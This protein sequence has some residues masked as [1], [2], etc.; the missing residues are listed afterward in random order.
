MPSRTNCCVVGCTNTYGSA[1]RNTR[2]Y[3]FPSKPHEIARRKKRV[4]AVK[5]V[6]KDGKPWTPTRFSRICSQHFVG[7]SKS[8]H[9]HSPA[10]VQS[11]FPSCYKKRTS[12]NALE[13]FSRLRQRSLGNQSTAATCNS[14]LDAQDAPALSECDEGHGEQDFEA[15]AKDVGTQTTECYEQEPDVPIMFCTIEAC[16]S[17]V[18]TSLPSKAPTEICG[19]TTVSVGLDPINVEVLREDA[20]FKGFASVS[21]KSLAKQEDILR[22][23]TSVQHSAFMMLLNIVLRSLGKSEDIADYVLLFL[24]KFKLGLSFSALGVLFG[25]HRT[26]A[27]RHFY[28]VLKCLTQETR[29]WIFW[30]S[31]AAVRSRLPKAFREKYPNC[32]GI[33]DCTEV[34]ICKPTEPDKA[35]E[36]S[37]S[38]MYSN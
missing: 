14:E 11:L 1:P 16:G 21:C 20:S 30:P 19:V 18:L 5:H 32:R 26:T 22:S 23:L 37:F 28:A 33:I 29:G 27:V 35:H 34:P 3:S 12:Q 36:G 31:A 7:G 24:M 8:D 15:G 25:I 6:T 9:P 2:F 4:S 13:R 17:S 10:Y 38:L